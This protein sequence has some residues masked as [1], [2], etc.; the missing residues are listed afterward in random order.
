M[1]TWLA[2]IQTEPLRSTFVPSWLSSFIV[3]SMSFSFGTFWISTGSSASSAAKRIGNAAFLAPEIV[4]S[5]WSVVG[6]CTRNL[7]II[8][9]SVKNSYLL[10]A[11]RPSLKNR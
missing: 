10:P 2:S 1:L 9:F 8:L 6:P 4:T 5:P 7:S 3:V 11:C